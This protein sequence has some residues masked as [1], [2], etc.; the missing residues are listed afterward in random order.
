MTVGPVTVTRELPET[1]RRAAV[2][3][4]WRMVA[5]AAFERIEVLRL[6]EATVYLTAEAARHASWRAVPATT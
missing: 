2:R 6:R 5:S 3:T 1:L 4:G